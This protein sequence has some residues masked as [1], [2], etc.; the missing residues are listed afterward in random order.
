MGAGIAVAIATRRDGMAIV[1]NFI[2]AS[3]DRYVLC[4]YRFTGWA[5]GRRRESGEERSVIEQADTRDLYT[6]LMTSKN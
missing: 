6:F 1:V 3:I 4:L 5:V 2:S